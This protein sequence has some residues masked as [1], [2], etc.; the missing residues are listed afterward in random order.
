MWSRSGKKAS[1][2]LSQI[3]QYNEKK[4][5]R[6][7]WSELKGKDKRKNEKKT[8]SMSYNGTRSDQHKF[9]RWRQA[10]LE[11]GFFFSVSIQKNIIIFMPNKA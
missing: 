1:S 9:Q 7:S 2:Y 3:Y 10:F 11:M 5:S 4:I 8:H 6:A